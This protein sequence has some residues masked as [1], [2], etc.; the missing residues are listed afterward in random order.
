MT[1]VIA[2]TLRRELSLRFFSLQGKVPKE[3][4]TILTETLEEHAPSYA[5]VKNWVARFKCGDFS[6]CDAPHPGRPK[7]VTTLD[8][9][10]QLHELILEDRRILAKSI[11][12]QLGI[13]HERVGSII[14]E[15]LDMRKLSAKWVTKCLNADQKHERCQSSEQLLGFFRHDPNYFLLGAIGDYG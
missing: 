10:D 1:R 8:I 6:T 5:T 3:I 7:T 14:H 4:H 9:I 13:S 15:D 2:T 11:A 12:Q